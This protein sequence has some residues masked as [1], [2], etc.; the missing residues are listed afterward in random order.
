M[1]TLNEWRVL[2]K[3]VEP[4]KREKQMESDGEECTRAWTLEIYEGE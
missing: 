2:D 1:E 4:W 3:C